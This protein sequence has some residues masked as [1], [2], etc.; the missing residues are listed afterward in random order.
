MTHLRTLE[1]PARGLVRSGRYAS[2]L[3]LLS[4]SGAALSPPAE[5]PFLDRRNDIA[6]LTMRN[7]ITAKNN[8][9]CTRLFHPNTTFPRSPVATSR[10]LTVM[11]ARSSSTSNGT[12]PVQRPE[13]PTTLRVSSDIAVAPSA[14]VTSSSNTWV[15]GVPPPSTPT[16]T[17][18][19]TL[20]SEST[21]TSA[22]VTAVTLCGNAVNTAPSSAP[23]RQNT[24]GR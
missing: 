6:N 12:T 3:L 20:C 24:R 1:G 4:S 17:L 22:T 18:I 11:P 16:S 14:A 2:V 21:C 7:D 13:R 19:E 23:A 15:P 10:A 5:L 9:T 8:S